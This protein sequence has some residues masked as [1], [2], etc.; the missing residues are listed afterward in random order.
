MRLLQ[1]NP[2]DTRVRATIYVQERSRF[3]V[4]PSGCQANSQRHAE[5]HFEPYSQTWQWLSSRDGAESCTRCESS[6][7][8]GRCLKCMV[9]QQDRNDMSV[10]LVCQAS[11][12]GKPK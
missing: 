3:E 9:A 2:C 7:P 4:K 1:F 10:G 11:I 6:R 5:L 8:C 12:R